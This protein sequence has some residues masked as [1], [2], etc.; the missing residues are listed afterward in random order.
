VKASAVVNGAP[1]A[2]PAMT[3]TYRPGT[4]SVELTFAGPLPRFA[5][6]T[7]DFQE[8]IKAPDGT[9]LAPTKLT[10]YTGG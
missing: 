4:L 8:G 7:L 10:F 5:T 9:P 3:V 2:M 1:T 6:V